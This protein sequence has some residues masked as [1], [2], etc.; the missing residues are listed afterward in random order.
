MNY[1]KSYKMKKKYKKPFLKIK[2]INQFTKVICDTCCCTYEGLSAQ[3][4]KDCSARRCV[5]GSTSPYCE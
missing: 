2:K 3:W 5:C 1:I 4:C